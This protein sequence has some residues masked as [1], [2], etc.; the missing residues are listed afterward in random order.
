MSSRSHQ[1]SEDEVYGLVYDLTSS[2]EDQLDRNEGVPTTYTKE[3][4]TID[5]WESTDGK[6]VDVGLQGIK[7][8]MLIYIDLERVADSKPQD[9]YIHR[10]NMGIKDAVDGAGLP[11]IYVQRA[12]RPFIPE[13]WRKGVEEL[14][15]KQA[16]D[17][18]EGR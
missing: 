10:M 18:A 13:Q 4:V 2:D 1:S 11:F 8:H 16:S 7:K 14:A 5:F 6:A 15:R 17:F 12:I 3:M 9:E